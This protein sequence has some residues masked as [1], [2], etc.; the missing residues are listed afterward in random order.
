M[1]P[2]FGQLALDDPLGP[3]MLT[4]S[5][6]VNTVDIFETPRRSLTWRFGLRKTVL[7]AL[8]SILL[9]AGC[10]ASDLEGKVPHNNNRTV[11]SRRTVP[12]SYDERGNPLMS[13]NEEKI[14]VDFNGAKSEIPTEVS[15]T[16][17]IDSN[18]KTII[19][20]D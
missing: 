20:V 17:S 5:S 11:L 9:L 1:K 18:G 2:C 3:W 8:S 10:A 7:F 13:L 15:V 19:S 16:E 4:P 6:R 14:G 12:L